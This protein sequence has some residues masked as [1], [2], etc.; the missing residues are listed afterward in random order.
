MMSRGVM[1]TATV[2]F[3]TA[4]VLEMGGFSSSLWVSEM[5]EVA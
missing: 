1:V 2:S 3:G 4:R 5:A